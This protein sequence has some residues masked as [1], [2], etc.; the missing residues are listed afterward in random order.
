MTVTVTAFYRFVT[1]AQPAD[2]QASLSA[3][4]EGLGIR[5]T[6][7]LAPEGINATIS[8][9]A[10]AIAHVLARLREDPRFGG[11][12]SKDSVAPEHP[13]QRFKVKLKPE[14]VTF[15]VP[16]ANPA[17]RAGTYVAPQDWN[18][19]I[20]DP[21]VFVLDTRNTYE[22]KIGTFPGARDPGTRSF[23]QFP[24]YVKANLDPKRQKKVAMF[25]TGGIRCEKASA[26]LLGQGF[27]QVYHLE[28]GILKYLET[29]PAA[30]S[31]WQGECF[32]FDERVALLHDLGPG[33]HEI[34]PACGQPVPKTGHLASQQPPSPCPECGGQTAPPLAR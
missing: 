11:M 28:G 12:A 14:I 8:G 30:E 25:C 27:E 18:A 31:M 10:D 2:L 4:G 7:L 26:Y 23:R 29:M 16:E 34:C 22:V 9:T 24:D 19:L 5:G 17:D 6:I 20:Q 13:F 33:Q 1:I 21:D 32:V 15:G 3:L